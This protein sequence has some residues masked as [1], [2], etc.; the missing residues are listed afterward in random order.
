MARAQSA[1]PVVGFVNYVGRK[2]AF[3]QGLREAG[4]VEGPHFAEAVNVRQENVP[5]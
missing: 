3:R 5:L 4:Y 1:V 2:P